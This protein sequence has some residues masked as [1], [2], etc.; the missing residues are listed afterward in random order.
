MVDQAFATETLHKVYRRVSSLPT[1][2][3]LLPHFVRLTDDVYRIPRGTEYSTVDTS[4][5]YHSMLLAAQMLSDRQVVGD[6]TRA[7]RAIKFE[8]LRDREGFVIHGLKDDG[9]TP[10]DCSWRDWGGETALVILLERMAKG[11]AAK[12]KMR[13]DGRVFHGVGFIAEIQSLFYPQFASEKPDAITG[14]NWFSVRRGLLN[15]QMEY[16]RKNSGR[17]AAAK[18]GVYGLSAGEGPRGVGYV[19]NGTEIPDLS[20][21]HPHYMLMSGLLRDR[22]S[23]LYAT[24]EVME[25]RGLIPPWGMIENVNADLTEYLPM[26]GSLNAAFECI[27]AYHLWARAMKQSD[28]IYDA[29]KAC[30]AL[31][32]AILTFYP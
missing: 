13:H 21:I 32:E 1:A 29:A 24:L 15:A 9:V 11:S 3:G 26:M 20:L 6:L 28:Q 22:P 25:K 16:F 7:I 30:P 31:E 14:T 10:L 23:D 17:S 5:Y 2:F 18:V 8:N 19:A 4:I 27:G 12:M